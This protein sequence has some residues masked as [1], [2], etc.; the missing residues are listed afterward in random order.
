MAQS[1]IFDFHPLFEDVQMNRIFADG[2]TFV[3][4]LPKYPLEEINKKYQLEKDSPGFNL[5]E[6]VISHFNLPIS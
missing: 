1:E 2:K 6:F 5:K 3:D 4:C